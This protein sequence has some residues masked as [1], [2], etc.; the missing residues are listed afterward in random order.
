MPTALALVTLT[1]AV[2][3]ARGS[4]VLRRS[5]AGHQAVKS[6]DGSVGFALADHQGTGSSR[7]TRPPGS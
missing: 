1:E 6:D 2:P 5:A 4:R 3:V 7:P